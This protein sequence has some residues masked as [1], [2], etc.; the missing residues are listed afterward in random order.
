MKM[1]RESS[2]QKPKMKHQVQR[3]AQPASFNLAYS[4]I[5]Q[6]VIDFL[7][8]S[9]TQYDVVFAPMELSVAVGTDE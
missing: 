5:Y 6:T 7:L 3:S 8:F 2:A 4:F 1:L 9:V